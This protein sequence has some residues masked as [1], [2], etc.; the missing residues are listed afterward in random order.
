MYL[1]GKVL[2]LALVAVAAGSLARGQ[3][4]VQIGPEPGCPYGYYDFAPYGCSPYGYYGPQWFRGGAF[5]GAGP[6]FHGDRGF[7]GYVDNRYDPHY[8]YRG[9]YP[10]RGERAFVHHEDRGYSHFRG[11][12][13]RDGRGHAF[14]DDHRR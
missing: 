5:I 7:H 11:N 14:H 8:G 3:V 2:G 4:S 13:Y 10:H 6:W 12:E 1:S 9:V